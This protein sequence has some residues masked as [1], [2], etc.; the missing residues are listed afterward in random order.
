MP[1]KSPALTT[2]KI[3]H[4]IFKYG[5]LPLTIYGVL[6]ALMWRNRPDKPNTPKPAEKK[7]EGGES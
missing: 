7:Q 5:I 3:Q 4:G 6:A 1:D 2:E